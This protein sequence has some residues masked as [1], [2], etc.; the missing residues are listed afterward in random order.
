MSP[1]MCTFPAMMCPMEKICI[2]DKR[3][4]GRSYSAFGHEFSVNELTIYIK[5][6]LNR[7]T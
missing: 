4:S 7:N 5:V 1:L 6:P 2:L 3:H